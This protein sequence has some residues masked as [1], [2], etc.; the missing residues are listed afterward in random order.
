MIDAVGERG[1]W[2]GGSVVVGDETGGYV[3]RPRGCHEVGL[4]PG[5][6]GSCATPMTPQLQHHAY[7]ENQNHNSR[8]IIVTRQ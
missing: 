5:G 7:K 3:T 6:G 8:L 2:R 4:S 1:T